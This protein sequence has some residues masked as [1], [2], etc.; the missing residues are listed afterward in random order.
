MTIARRRFLRSVPAAVAAGMT[1]PAAVAAQR[2]GQT[3]PRFSKDALKCADDVDGLRFT[4]AEHEM[5]LSGASRNLDAYDELRKLEV[6]LDTE[7]AITF[8]PAMPGKQPRGKSARNARLAVA[9][10]TVQASSGSAGLEHL[11]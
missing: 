6:P 2:G 11:A 5:A 9:K 3:P 7:P 10:P 4:D 1:L 8:R